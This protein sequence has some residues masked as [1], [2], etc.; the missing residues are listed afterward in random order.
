MFSKLKVVF[1]QRR[2]LRFLFSRLLRDSTLLDRFKFHYNYEGFSIRLTRSALSLALWIDRDDRKGDW[3]FISRV[4]SLGDVFVD[5]GA[6]I[7][8]LSLLASKVVGPTG[9]VFAIEAHPRTYQDLLENV[10]ANGAD[11]IYAINVAASDRPSWLNFT[12][13]KTA[14][15]QNR[16]DSKGN[17]RVFS[18][19]LDLIVENEHVSL[20]KIDTEGFEKFIF[21]G[22]EN[23]LKKTSVI[24]F[25]AYK[26]HYD[27]FGYD[28]EFIYDFLS[29]RGFELGVITPKGLNIINGSY[30]P[31]QC[32]NIVAWRHR[33]S[34]LRKT[35]FV[36]EK[37][38]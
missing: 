3:I 23:L 13:E 2:P 31:W 19:P 4:L 30:V 35:E 26:K 7:G 29:A 14:N 32:T 37:A 9:K 24:Y 33:E 25:E 27:A 10:R 21:L 18:L 28:F 34:F 5:V 6:H 36:L 11:N 1:Q 17:L 8:H 12:D 20:L 16:V 22:A 15:D 38:E